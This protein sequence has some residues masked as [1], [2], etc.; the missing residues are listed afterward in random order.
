MKLTHNT[1]ID[2]ASYLDEQ[3]LVK[4]ANEVDDLI[5]N[6]YSFNKKAALAPQRLVRVHRH[7]GEALYKARVLRLF[8]DKRTPY[9]DVYEV[10]YESDGEIGRVAENLIWHITDNGERPSGHSI[11]LSAWDIKNKYWDNAWSDPGSLIGA[12]AEEAGEYIPE[13]MLIGTLD[14]IGL[15]PGIGVLADTT[16]LLWGLDEFGKNIDISSSLPQD[17]EELKAQ[18]KGTSNPGSCNAIAKLLQL[19]R[20]G[21]I[22]AKGLF[23]VITDVTAIAGAFLTGGLGAP[24]IAL[25]DSSAELI[26][27]GVT[28]VLT[29]Q[30]TFSGIGT[31]AA[32][33]KTAIVKILDYL[34]RFFLAA[35]QPVQL[36][37]EGVVDEK[38]NQLYANTTVMGAISAVV[39]KSNDKAGQR[40]GSPSTKAAYEYT[41]SNM[42][43]AIDILST[44]S[45]AT[46][47]LG[48]SEAIGA[49]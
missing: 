20:W 45:A 35:D 5:C 12:A 25:I 6:Q 10:Q 15:I 32:G 44:L 9:L 17:I 14:L 1:L 22:L 34:D 11:A 29:S 28:A 16:T 49:A 33:V 13:W 7:K 48:W 18:C 36:A 23:S 4:E 46:D 21:L 27:K 41:R 31:F 2:L 30:L 24:V 42:L 39:S 8:Q 37:A 19:I 3:G 43:N 47:D 26:V 38:G 40:L